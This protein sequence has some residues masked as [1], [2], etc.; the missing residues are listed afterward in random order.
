MELEPKWGHDFHSAIA[1]KNAD[2]MRR[3]IANGLPI[4]EHCV[5]FENE[6][7]PL[8]YA[9]DQNP[10]PSVVEVL[11]AAGAD[12]NAPVI[13]R[14]E[15]RATPLGLVARRG[16]LAIVKQLLAAGADV[17]YTEKHN[18]TPLSNSTWYNKPANE[19]VMKAL[20]AAGAKSNYQALVGAARKGSP[21]MIEML[22]AS[23]ADVNEISRWGTALILA[24]SSKRD[25]TAT[26]LLRAGADPH[27]RLP[28]THP[29]FPGQTA[30]DVAKK[31]KAKKVIAILEAALAGKVLPAPAP[32]PLDNVP[33][34]WKR[35]EKALK[36]SPAV[37]KSLN[38]G[39][40]PEQIAACETA[41]GVAFPPDLRDSYL[42]HDG[43]KTGSDGLF[44]EGFADLDSEFALLSLEEIVRE[45]TVWKKLADAGEFKNQQSQPD[46]GVRSD[47]WNPK[48]VPF[49]ADGGGDSLCVDLAPAEGG[50]VGQVILHQHADDARAKKATGVQSLLHLLGEH[51][52]EQDE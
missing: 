30:L 16:N 47:W 45:W 32:K 38:K 33:K 25:D 6:F 8:Q 15:K 13:E 18:T 39:A 42:I 10:D 9:I 4:N 14:G 36:A 29:N 49:A 24:A 17:N 34:L 1:Q 2:A 37:K 31:E 35:I 51:L 52:S 22:A 41:L 5:G 20:L 46:A 50:T 44:P 3:A 48:W 21:A 19:A 28:D 7:T 26:A 11:I 23:G 12:V 40:T 43:Q 27:L